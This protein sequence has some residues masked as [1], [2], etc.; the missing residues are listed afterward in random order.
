MFDLCPDHEEKTLLLKLFQESRA[1]ILNTLDDALW[2]T[3]MEVSGA[4]FR[5]VPR[6]VDEVVT[7]AVQDVRVE[8]E[9]RRVRLDVTPGVDVT[10]NCEND[11]ID[12]AVLALLQEAIRFARPASAITV[13]WNALGDQLALEVH[14]QGDVLP[15]ETC[16]GFFHIFSQSR[17]NT[18]AEGLALAPVVAARVIELHGGS[19]E[20]HAVEHGGGSFRLNLPSWR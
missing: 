20:M 10:I 16:D 12:M 8:A 17:T 6:L 13:C 15:Q 11:W 2:L 1:R 14:W 18:R 9:A 5:L 7:Q 3:Q 19:V 4:G